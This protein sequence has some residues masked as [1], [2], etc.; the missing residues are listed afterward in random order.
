MKTSFLDFYYTS[1]SLGRMPTN[2]LC[3]AFKDNKIFNLIDPEQGLCETYW[4]AD[5]QG[6]EFRRGYEFTELRQNVV[7]LCAA[8]NNEL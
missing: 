4:G 8:I 2:G 6:N 5:T 1:I 7:L 3:H